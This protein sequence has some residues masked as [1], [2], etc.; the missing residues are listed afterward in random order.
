MKSKEKLLEIDSL[1]LN[2]GS[3]KAVKGI[4]LYLKKN[5]IVTL[6]GA[7]GAGK[8]SLLK[9]IMNIEKTKGDIL[10][11]NNKIN[12]LATEKI[13]N[14]G[15]SIIPEGH[16]IFS[17]MTVW[18]NLQLGVYQGNKDKDI[19][20]E[21]IYNYF[22]ILEKRKEQKAG[23]L[24]GG[25]QQMLSIGRALLSGPELLLVDEPSLGLAPQIVQDIFTILKKLNKDGF[26]IL[27]AEQNVK[28][29]LEIADRAYVLKTGEIVREGKANDML[30][31]S[32]FMDLYL[33]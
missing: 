25:E 14:K 33:N 15:I 12:N 26:T 11:K 1:Y 17:S 31:E 5:E 21:E 18:E 4:S 10:F 9:G 8:S 13:V 20:L 6:V 22:P 28:K 32:N 19:T 3:I 7:N 24:S 30:A 29:S 16:L 27:L 2:Y 23:T